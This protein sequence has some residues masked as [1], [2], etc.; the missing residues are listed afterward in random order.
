MWR[1]IG[2]GV[3]SAGIMPLLTGLPTE[4]PLRELKKSLARH[5][6]SDNHKVCAEVEARERQQDRVRR[7]QGMSNG[8]AV[9][10]TIKEGASYTSYER[11]V[12]FLDLNGVDVG[13]INHG[14]KF[15][16]G[17]V[18]S[19]HA[20]VQAGIAQFLSEGWEVIGGRRRSVALLADKVTKLR[21]T[22][23]LSGAVFLHDGEL[24]CVML[25]NTVVAPDSNNA[26]GLAQMLVNE[27]ETLMPMQELRSRCASMAFDGQYIC[28]GVPA[29]VRAL[30]GGTSRW[31][32]AMWDVAHKNELVVNDCR[33]DKDGTEDL[34]SVG[35]LKTVQDTITKIQE[36]FQYG[37]A[38]EVVLAMAAET[39]EP[40]QAPRTFCSMRFVTSWSTTVKNFLKNFKTYAAYYEDASTIPTG[41]MGKNRKQRTERIKDERT[42]FKL[43]SRLKDQLFVGRV[44]IVRDL[45]QHLAKVRLFIFLV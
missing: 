37:K 29:K 36:K 21:R 15:C 25:G 2:C 5:F 18:R 8:R 44:L 12:F 17:L 16:A 20:V 28:E 7:Q 6:A 11:R 3:Q 30:L 27:A 43:L 13:S 23:Q 24:Q 19:L 34:N 33:K 40:L 22:A 1:N 14:R 35:W 45:F 32:T 4:Q 39:D 31:R 38:F 10:A 26:A 9:Y 42:A 41:A